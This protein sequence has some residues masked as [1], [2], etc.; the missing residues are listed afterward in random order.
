[1]RKGLSQA[2]A[3]ETAAKTFMNYRTPARVMD[4]RWMGQA[5]QGQAWL[6]FPKYSYGRLK[7][8]YS[9]LKGSAKLDPQSMDQLL[10]I[11]VLYE[12][13]QHVLNPLIRQYTEQDNAEF[14]NYGYT[15]FPELADKVYEGNRSPGQALQSLAAPGYAIQGLD[16]VR[17]T[18]PYT[19]RPIAVPGE[20][21]GE[22]ALDYVGTALNKLS[23]VQRY[24]QVAKGRI[25]PDDV[26]LQQLGVKFPAELPR[27]VR[28]QL[29]ARQKYGS[30]IE[31]EFGQ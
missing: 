6:D 1:M 8:L 14:G 7:G 10:M 17:G 3:T 9:M 27:S 13:G 28:K 30:Q 11:A 29:K 22:V 4:Q 19:G 23:P 26:W 24:G 18:D 15:V 2:E 16:M 25:T 31:Q 5:L 12:F 20:S 21:P